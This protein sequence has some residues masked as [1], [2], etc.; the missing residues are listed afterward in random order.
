L[1]IYV[2]TKIHIDL[3]SSRVLMLVL[4]VLNSDRQWW[5]QHDVSWRKRFWL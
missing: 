3:L 4:C 1:I 5:K 2:F